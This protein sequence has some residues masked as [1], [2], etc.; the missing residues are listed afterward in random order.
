MAANSLLSPYVGKLLH[1][2]TGD[3][4]L[5]DAGLARV[6]AVI[7]STQ[8]KNH[9]MPVLGLALMKPDNFRFSL[10]KSAAMS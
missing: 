6:I 9:V 7:N 8:Q 10:G 1:L 2:L 5:L 4:H 3:V